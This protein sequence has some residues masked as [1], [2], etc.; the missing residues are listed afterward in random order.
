MKVR[1]PVLLAVAAL[2]LLAV[3]SARGTSGIP[4]G[5]VV[6]GSSPVAPQTTPS[7]SSDTS[8]QP[9]AYGAGVLIVLVA[10]MMMFGLS[11]FLFT[12]TTVRLWRRRGRRVRV[13][14]LLVDGEFEASGSWLARATNRAL[15]EMDRRVGGPPSDAVIAAWVRLEE[16][17]AASG[18]ERAPHQTPS[19]FTTKVLANHTTDAAALKEL[20]ALYHRARFGPPGGVTEE[21]VAKARRALERIALEMAP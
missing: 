14:A 7:S 15:S 1:L 16:D 2:V 12:L 3:V 4:T 8:L 13:P 5:D 9:I 21:D 20:R 17:A 19:E 10:I 6:F 18:T 11:V